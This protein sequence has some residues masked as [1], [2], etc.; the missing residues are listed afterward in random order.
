MSDQRA[1]EKREVQELSTRRSVEGSGQI[2]SCRSS[3]TFTPDPPLIL[4]R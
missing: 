3:A 2:V 1:E 4:N